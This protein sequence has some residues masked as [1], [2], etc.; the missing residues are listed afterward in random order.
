MGAVSDG[1]AP[2]G[3]EG[4]GEIRVRFSADQMR[5]DVI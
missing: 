4:L 5:L 3:C 1:A 2:V